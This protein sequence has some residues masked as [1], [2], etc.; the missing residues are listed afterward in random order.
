MR[1]ING[2][3]DVSMDVDIDQYNSTENSPGISLKPD[4]TR[5]PETLVYF[6]VCF[7]YF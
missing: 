1:Y 7:V 3:K 2:F 4:A 5:V 6:I